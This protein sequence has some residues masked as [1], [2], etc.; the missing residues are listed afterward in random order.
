M[1]EIKSILQL[2]E[3]FV[4]SKDGGLTSKSRVIEKIKYD[5]AYNTIC[6]T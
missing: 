5:F 3:A 6:I 1:R 2:N 4:T